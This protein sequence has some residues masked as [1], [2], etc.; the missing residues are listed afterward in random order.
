MSDPTNRPGSDEEWE[1][2]VRQL[3]RQPAPQPRPFFY[4][5]VHA[6]LL[7]ELAPR[8]TGLPGWA[9]RPAFVALLSILML[10]MSRDGADLRPASRPSQLQSFTR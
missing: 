10:A 4:A 8:P 2:L 1:A 6:R 5:R 9:R 7:A 3:H